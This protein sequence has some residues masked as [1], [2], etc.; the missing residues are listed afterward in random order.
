MIETPEDER[1]D[2]SKV[3]VLTGLGAT[4]LIAIIMIG[5]AMALM[6]LAMSVPQELN[7]WAGVALG[8]LF[9]TFGSI[10][11]DFVTK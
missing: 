7:Q 1:W 10:L 2:I 9:G 4:I 8:F 6:L 11:K 5:T 3:I